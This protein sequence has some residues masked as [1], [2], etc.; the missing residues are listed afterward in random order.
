MDSPA[1]Q[2]REEKSD[3]VYALSPNAKILKDEKDAKDVLL[4]LEHVGAR[5]CGSHKISRIVFRCHCRQRILV[6][7]PYLCYW[8]GRARNLIALLTAYKDWLVA[9]RAQVEIG[10]MRKCGAATS[11]AAR[12]GNT[13]LLLLLLLLLL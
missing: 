12:C 6:L 3:S 13:A 8:R 7:D 2:C 11:T 9:F 1:C 4:V 10:Q 5:H